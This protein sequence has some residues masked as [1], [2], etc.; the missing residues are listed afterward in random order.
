MEDQATSDTEMSQSPATPIRKKEHTADNASKDTNAETTPGEYFGVKTTHPI[1]PCDV[2]NPI[3]DKH[4][5]R[6]TSKSNAKRKNAKKTEERKASLLAT[7]PPVKDTPNFHHPKSVEHSVRIEVRWAPKDFHKLRSSKAKMFSRLAP[8]LSCF[9]TQYTWMV[10]WQTDQMED[11]ADIDPNQLAKF[12]S[13]RIVPVIKEQ[14]FY[15]SFR[16]CATGSQFTQVVKS[17]VMKTAKMGER[18]SFDPTS[19]HPQQGELIFVGNILLKDASNTHRGQYLRYLRKEVLPEGTPAFDIK[20]RHKDPVGNPVKILAV[21]CGKANSTKVAEILSSALCGEGKNAE[22]FISRLAIGANQTSK[23]E[24]AQ[25]YQVHMDYLKDI[26]CIPFMNPA[27]DTPVTEYLE[28][29]STFV[30][31]P[32]QWAK[33]LINDD[34]TP[35]EI[36]IENGTATGSVILLVPSASVDKAKLE[37]NKYWARQN[38]SLSNATELYSASLT[39][40]PDIPRTVFTKN[41]ATILSKRFKQVPTNEHDEASTPASSL[42]GATSKSS[43]SIAWKTPLQ[44]TLRKTTA[45]RQ[46]PLSSNEINQ[47]KRIAILEAQLSITQTNDQSVA[48]SSKASSK[49]SKSSRS[50]QS[51]KSSQASSKTSAQSPLTAATAHSRLD[52]LEDAMLDIRRLLKKIA[53]AQSAALPRNDSPMKTNDDSSQE[54]DASLTTIESPPS[55]L[56]KGMTSVQLFP[57]EPSGDTTLA[58]LSTPKKPGNKRQ[59]PTSSPSPRQ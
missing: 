31:T 19:I 32:R 23:K 4:P 26:V 56:A 24:H 43:T 34:G 51:T 50:K 42:T 48:T 16:I 5:P 36:D 22:I 14:A 55:S 45:T 13:T 37:A 44:D 25:I 40:N 17:E 10:E 28:S 59:K 46:K 27:I 41:I 6:A 58:L 9:N 39:A 2:T 52:S 54:N 12:L 11:S 57:P 53:V 47:L 1:P 30:Q 15:F 21:R 38:P 20:V 29:G 8:I 33:S 3:V 18:M 49:A 35:L 7:N